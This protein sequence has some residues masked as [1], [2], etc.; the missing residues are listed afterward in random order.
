MKRFLNDLLSS[1]PFNGHKLNLGLALG[2]LL[3]VA[4]QVLAFLPPGIAEITSAVFVLV[5]AVHKFV[6]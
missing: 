3:H 5:G 1:L 4:P 6:K 2:A